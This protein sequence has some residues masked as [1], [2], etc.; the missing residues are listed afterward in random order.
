MIALA[1]VTVL[2]VLYA[3]ETAPAV[4][5]IQSLRTLQWHMAAI[6][7]ADADTTDKPNPG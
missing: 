4:A 3:N 7:A 1:L 2:A 6:P 5:K